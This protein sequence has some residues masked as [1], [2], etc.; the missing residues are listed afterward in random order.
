MLTNSETGNTM[1]ALKKTISEMEQGYH[2]IMSFY[3]LAEELASTVD[4]QFVKD[5]ASQLA[6]VEP[7]IEQLS[8]SADV[9]TEEYI[10]LA[11]GKPTRKTRDRIEVSLRKIYNAMDDYQRK[12]T[13]G[14]LGAGQSV[15]NIADPVIYRIKLKIEEVI[16]AFLDFIKLSLDRVM[17]KN[18]LEEL[19]K[20]HHI[21]F[22]LH[23]MA[24]QH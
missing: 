2:S 1:A 7:L 4:S 19:K 16:V 9:L 6:L 11:D 15:K 18:D 5:P 13:G 23:Q 21:T 17:H 12:L 3:D 22:Q 20:R 14:L 10:N 24:Q 8:D